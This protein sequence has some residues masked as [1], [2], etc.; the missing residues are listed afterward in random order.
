MGLFNVARTA[1]GAAEC[2][3]AP[4][5]WWDDSGCIRRCLCV[6]VMLSVS[7]SDP[8]RL[9]EFISRTGLETKVMLM[10]AVFD[11]PYSVW[12]SSVVITDVW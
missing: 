12:Y 1:N 2:S 4:R 7:P 3:D 10:C 8:D 11:S 6:Q 5:R 9:D